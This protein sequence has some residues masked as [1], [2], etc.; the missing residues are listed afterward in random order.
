MNT[1]EMQYLTILADI[2]DNGISK[3][4]RTG[5][6]TR[7]IWTAYM[8]MNLQHGFPM[9]TTRF[10]P[11]RLAF[12]ETMFFLRGLTDTKEL[13]KRNIKIWT[14]NTTREFLDSAG[15]PHLPEGDMG[16]G[17]GFQ[18]R[19]FM[20]DDGSQGVDQIKDLLDGL[21]NDP[22]GR[23]HIVSA[24]N[25]K[26]LKEMALP[27]C[28]CFWQCNV[29]N[30]KLNLMFYMRSS[31]FYHGIGFNIAS[32]A[33]I[34]HLFA[35]LLGLEVGDL[36]Y[37]AGD[38]HLYETQL[39]VVQE[40]LTRTPIDTLPTINFKK[41]FS[42]LEEMLSLEFEDVELVGYEHRGKLKKVPMAV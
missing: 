4:D 36:V 19:N 32:Y 34:T 5:T 12:E 14:G 18:W 39:E 21:K 13:E 25:P 16:K 10:V 2:K 40:Q 28:H 9:I 15:L 6:G 3:F 23:R 38:V 37:M 17:Y 27:P 7:S 24:W 22:N 30:G 42:T 8:K 31:D 35:K 1:F 11:F 20:G 41:D 33:L 29:V 26:Q